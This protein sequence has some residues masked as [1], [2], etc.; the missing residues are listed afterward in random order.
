[1]E[2]EFIALTEVTKELLITE[3]YNKHI[4]TDQQTKPTLLVDNMAFI[5]FIKSPIENYQTKHVD[6]KLFFVCDLLNQAIFNVKH[7]PSKKN[8]SV[9]FTK[10]GLNKFIEVVFNFKSK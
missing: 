5:D 7:V 4:F 10:Y 1:M 9:V 2:S 6:V 3:C 8:L